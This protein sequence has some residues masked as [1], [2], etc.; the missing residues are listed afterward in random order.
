MRIAHPTSL[1]IIAASPVTKNALSVGHR[2]HRH[3][4]G[5]CETVVQQRQT[6]TVQDAA[7]DARW[8][9]CTERR[10][11]YSA[12]CGTPLLWPDDEAFGTIAM[13]KTAPF[14]DEQ[15]RSGR[16][17]LENLASGMTAQLAL[18]YHAQK[19]HEQN[20][21]DA[22]TGLP[23][24]GLLRELAEQQMQKPPKQSAQLW[25]LVWTIDELNTP[26]NQHL[27]GAADTFIR[28]ITERATSCIRLSDTIARIDAHRFALLISDAN[29]FV[30]TAVAD[31]IRR[32]VRRVSSALP[33]L[34]EPG[35][36]VG[37]SPYQNPETFDVWFGRAR[38]TLEDATHSGHNQ[39]LVRV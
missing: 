25:L 21:H 5:Y 26:S 15:L 17:L 9:G 23:K 30:A 7:H 12:Y 13:L 19:N 4:N 39:T 2:E 22:L 20:T 34:S 11:G 38:A 18:L 14:S 33:H 27:A 29:E 6:L 28:S 8:D 16:R 24:L 35:M 3:G 10:A 1:E 31:R 37:I 32:N 36:S